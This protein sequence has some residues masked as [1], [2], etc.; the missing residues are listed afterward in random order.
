MNQTTSRWMVQ[1]ANGW[2]PVGSDEELL[3]WIQRGWAGP[4]TLVQGLGWPAPAPLGGVHGFAHLFAS[5]GTG[6]PAAA[7]SPG[8]PQRRRRVL[9]G[10]GQLVVLLVAVLWGGS[11]TTVSVLTIILGVGLAAAVVLSRRARMP[12][13]IWGDSALLGMS[14]AALLIG[15]GAGL[16]LRVSRI[17]ECRSEVD[18]LS[19]MKASGDLTYDKQGEWPFVELGDRATKA[20]SVCE[21]AGN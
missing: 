4:A 21:S 5:T 6:A 14:A 7:R 9:C 19:A 12:A 20:V 2:Q 13:T 8:D 18:A 3:G 17:M 10:V 16:A 11:S 15:G 1:T